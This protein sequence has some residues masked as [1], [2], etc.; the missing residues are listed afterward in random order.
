MYNSIYNPET[1]KNYNIRSPEG[2][3]T[4]RNFMIGGAKNP[5]NKL[6]K[7]K[8][9]KCTDQ[10]ECKWVKKLGCKNKQTLGPTKKQQKIKLIKKK[11]PLL[12]DRDDVGRQVLH[13]E[14][15]MLL[16]KKFRHKQKFKITDEILDKFINSETY[17][18]II[19]EYLR[20]LMDGEIILGRRP[21]FASPY[22]NPSICNSFKKTKDPKCDD[23]ELCEWG[24]KGKWL[25]VGCKIS[26]QK[27]AKRNETLPWYE[28]WRDDTTD[29]L[30]KAYNRSYYTSMDEDI[31]P[32]WQKNYNAS[33][34]KRNKDYDVWN[35]GHCLYNN[36]I[37]GVSVEFKSGKKNTKNTYKKLYK[38]LEKYIR[39]SIHTRIA[40][41]MAHSTTYLNK[42]DLAA[43]LKKLVKDGLRITGPYQVKYEPI[44]FRFAQTPKGIPF[45]D[46]KKIDHLD[47]WVKYKAHEC[48]L[49][50][51][52][53]GSRKESPIK[54]EYIQ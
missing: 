36:K 27:L 28:G 3:K 29:V 20:E 30:T 42:R 46:S 44:P 31:I 17:H 25:G 50:L 53:W 5:C 16:I 14:V 2:I 49:S 51:I 11:K 12:I 4:L 23:Q 8:D 39:R 40:W 43:V 41:Q 34:W 13:D 45:A 1:N 24:D 35:W 18:K 19:A 26:E 48:P 47:A 22:I 54:E 7:T 33:R 52:V 9:P 6:K 38:D 21:D 10:K 37:S 32:P 15:A